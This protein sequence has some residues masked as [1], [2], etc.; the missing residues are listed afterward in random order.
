MRRAVVFPI[1]AVLLLLLLPLAPHGAPARAQPGPDVPAPDLRAPSSDASSAS[2]ESG[3][4]LRVFLMTF[5]DGS[6]IYEKFG[7]NTICIHDPTPSAEV[8]ARRADTDARYQSRF[9]EGIPRVSPFLPTDKAYH[10]GAFDFEQESFVW[11]FLHGRME[12]WMQ[13][14]WADYTA[15]AYAADNRAVLLQELDLPPARKRELQQFLAWN[16]RPENRTYRYDYYRDNCSTRVRDAIDRATG[17]ELARQ[18][19]AVRTD[20][21]YRSHTRRVTG[22]LSLEG[23]FWFTSFTYVLGHPVDVRLSAWEE[24]FLPERLADHVRALRVPDGRGGSRPL[25]SGEASLAETTRPPLPQ[26]EPR[27]V[28]AYGAAGL[29]VGGAFAGLALLARRRRAARIALALVVAP[30][31]LLWGVGAVIGTY[32]WALT[33]HAASYDN[34]NLLQM[35]ILMVPLVYL[36]PAVALGR[37][38]GAGLAAKLAVAVAAMSVLGFALQALPWFWQQNG[39]I[40]TLALPANLGLAAALVRLRRQAQ[41]AAAEPVTEPGK[42][43]AVTGAAAAAA[44]GS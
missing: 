38:R 15:L 27:R 3:A 19:Q 24:C 5:S 6:L 36:A 31:A 21:T 29:L 33:D 32:G 2:A 10:Y 28:V 34:E 12:Y 13:S 40:V 4:D 1:V 23:L 22:Q 37:R 26:V 20:A 17:G 43:S 44:R 9:D 7:H 39:E 8:V 11:R 14:E 16:E 35:S 42:G 30:W 18:L 41:R 25:V